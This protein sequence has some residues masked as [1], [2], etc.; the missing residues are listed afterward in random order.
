MTEHASDELREKIIT[1]I[2]E[3]SELREQG[4]VTGDYLESAAIYERLMDEGAG[5]PD[6]ALSAVLVELA[7]QERRIE[8]TPD[9]EARGDAVREHGA[10]TIHDARGLC[11]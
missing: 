3:W 5:V 6:R 7:S 1:I 2:C 10:I 8:I 4:A 11:S 9:I